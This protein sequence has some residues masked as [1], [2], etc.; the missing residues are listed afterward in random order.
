MK[1]IRLAK[2]WRPIWSPSNWNYW[3]ALL[4]PVCLAWW[5]RKAWKQAWYGALDS[6]THTAV[7]SVPAGVGG[8]QGL[9]WAPSPNRDLAEA[10]SD[11]QQSRDR[12]AAPLCSCCHKASDSSRPGKCKL[13]RDRWECQASLYLAKPNWY[14]MAGWLV[15]WLTGWPAVWLA[16]WLAGC[17]LQQAKDKPL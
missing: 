3:H 8:G 13:A 7:I 11:V 4:A 5:L 2:N 17:C 6:A 12:V 16:G 14:Q 15:G 9:V 1:P 10:G